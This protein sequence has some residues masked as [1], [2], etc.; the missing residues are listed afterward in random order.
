MGKPAWLA[1]E[2]VPQKRTGRGEGWILFVD[3][4]RMGTE[5][6]SERE[7]T[8]LRQTAGVEEQLAA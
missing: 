4:A 2:E 8:S 6:Y 1:G 5:A 7:D 3:K